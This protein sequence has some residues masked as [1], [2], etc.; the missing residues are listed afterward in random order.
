MADR[1]AAPSPRTASSAVLALLTAAGVLLCLVIVSS[2]VPALTWSIALAVALRRPYLWLLRKLSRPSLTA[3]LATVLVLILLVAPFVLLLQSLGSQVMGLIPLVQSGAAQDWANGMLARFPAVDHLLLRV[4]GTIN[5]KQGLQASAGYL[6]SKLQAILAGS[7][8]TVTQLGIMLY[9]LFFLFR[10]GDRARAALGSLLPLRPEQSVYL[11]TR[12]A[13]AVQATVLGSLSIAAI[14][15]TLGGLMFAILG[16]PNAPL[17]AFSMAM[18]ATIP[19]LG[20]FLVWAPVAGYLA[21]TGSLVKAAILTGWGVGVIGTVDN[22][23][24]PMLVSSRLKM[25]TAATFFA[26]LGGIA[27][28]GISGLVLGPLILVTTVELLRLWSP[29]ILPEGAEASRSHPGS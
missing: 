27:A 5:I 4:T 10:D 14:Q 26:V 6:G 17:W 18:L 20:T 28:F 29:A 9:T 12:M 11:L 8:R 1:P 24:Y 3:V 15:G 13:A 2:F 25:H 23:L 16:V 19:S 7:L 21:L 22:I